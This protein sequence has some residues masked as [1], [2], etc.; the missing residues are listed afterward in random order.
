M[1]KDVM[2]PVDIAK[3][4]EAVLLKASKSKRISVLQRREISQATSQL[5]RCRSGRRSQKS[6]AFSKKFY[7]ELLLKILPHLL[8]LGGTLIKYFP[9]LK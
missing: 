7:F 2:I 3:N 9:H 6:V 5:Q 1:A 4:L 8:S